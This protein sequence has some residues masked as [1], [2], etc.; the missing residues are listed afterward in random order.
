MRPDS[1]A[2]YLNRGLICLNVFDNPVESL[3]KAFFSHG[4]TGNDHPLSVLNTIELEDI[5][6]LISQLRLVRGR[7][8][9]PVCSRKREPVHLREQPLREAYRA[10]LPP[11]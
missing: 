8:P 9:C 1:I 6:D 2:N 3:R 10:R 7:E 4:G 5:D 11:H